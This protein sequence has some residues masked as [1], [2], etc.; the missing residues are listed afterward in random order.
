MR[1]VSTIRSSSERRIPS[2]VKERWAIIM[3]AVR[4]IRGAEYGG[5]LGPSE[6]LPENDYESGPMK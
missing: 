1:R 4:M 6:Q 5:Y 3:L 2:R